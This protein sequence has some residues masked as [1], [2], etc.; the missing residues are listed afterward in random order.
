MLVGVSLSLATA[1]LVP[2]LPLASSRRALLTGA[3]QAPALLAHAIMVHP[4]PAIAAEAAFEKVPQVT[5][6]SWPGVEYMGAYPPSYL[7]SSVSLPRLALLLPSALVSPRSLS[8]C[9]TH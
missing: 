4:E 5:V 6:L 2:E 3:A 7:A 1:A 9:I 8:L